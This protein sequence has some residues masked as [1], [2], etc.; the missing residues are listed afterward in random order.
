MSDDAGLI[1][2]SALNHY[3]YCPRRCALV[4]IE[5]QW[6]ENRFTIEGQVLH[7]HVDS[8]ESSNT[9]GIRVVRSLS[10][11]SQ[12]LGLVGR[13]DVVEFHDNGTI[14]PV[15]YKR[16]KPKSNQSDEVQLCAQALCLE[17]M[18]DV[19][20]PAGALFYG[21]R[22]RRKTVGFDSELRQLVETIAGQV[23]ELFKNGKTPLAEYSKKCDHCSLLHSC[24]P[25]S[26]RKNRSVRRYMSR[27]LKETE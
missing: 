4:H 24:M 15:E 8:N 2:I 11:C 7:E 18:L 1:S 17:E 25:K 23:H 20:I 9:G 3:L 19:E 26:C 10:I 16:G 13:A 6:F 21:Q 5:Q 12:S 27:M 14:F 22:H